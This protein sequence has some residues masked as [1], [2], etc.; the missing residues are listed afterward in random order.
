MRVDELEDEYAKLSREL[1]D[2]KYKIRRA[3]WDKKYY[4]IYSDGYINSDYCGNDGTDINRYVIGNMFKTEE[5]AQKT[6]KKIKIYT[7]LKELAL[8]L[9]EGEEVDWNDD[10]QPK[11]CIKR[12]IDDD[13]L[14]CV[15]TY[16]VKDVGQIYCLN[17]NFLNVAVEKIGEETLKQLL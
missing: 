5:E 10:A 9:N 12:T 2:L 11:W 3:D 14:Y 8:S 13:R 7:R 6:I 1:E 4:Y 15:S 17:E 16:V